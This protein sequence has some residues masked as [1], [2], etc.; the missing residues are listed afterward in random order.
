MAN[1]LIRL[2]HITAEITTPDPDICTLENQQFFVHGRVATPA[3]AKVEEYSRTYPSLDDVA[4]CHA[5]CT[6]VLPSSASSSV[7]ASA[8]MCP[9]WVVG[10]C[11]AG[12]T[13]AIC[14]TPMRDI[15][16][17]STAAWA[18]LQQSYK[19]LT[20]ALASH[21]L[22]HLLLRCPSLHP[23]LHDHWFLS[24]QEV[25]LSA[26]TADFAGIK[27]TQYTLIQISMLWYVISA[28]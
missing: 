1:S 12:V 19:I 16:W 17:A 5:S 28:T 22:P 14:V 7:P 24:G 18:M 26:I 10:L 4:D 6:V 23:S 21:H 15:L 27:P 20:L 2:S 9:R 11:A 3:A 8:K 13:H 25:R